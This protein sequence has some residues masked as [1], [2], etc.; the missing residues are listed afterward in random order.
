MKQ[1]LIRRESHARY[2]AILFGEEGAST[3]LFTEC[4]GE[5]WGYTPRQT[6]TP[7]NSFSQLIDAFSWGLGHTLKDLAYG[8][9]MT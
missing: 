1:F 7:F 3:P 2:N 6:N 9:S 4:G 8:R 5:M